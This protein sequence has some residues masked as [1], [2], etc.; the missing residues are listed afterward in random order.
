MNLQA[1]FTC[2]VAL[3]TCVERRVVEIRDK[4]AYIMFT[5]PV[6]RFYG[7]TFRSMQNRNEVELQC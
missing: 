3:K 5:S 6:Y 2:L 4:G 1:T 7:F